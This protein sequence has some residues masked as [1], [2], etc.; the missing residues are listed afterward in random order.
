MTP[1]P[2]IDAAIQRV[3]EMMALHTSTYGEGQYDASDAA[4][5][6]EATQKLLPLAKEDGQLARYWT[7]IGAVAVLAVDYITTHHPIRNAKGSE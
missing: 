4:S 5:D 3:R 7:L 2:S 6:L 1:D